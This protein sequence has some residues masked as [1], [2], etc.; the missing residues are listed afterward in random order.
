MGVLMQNGQAVAY[1]SRYLK[2]NDMNYSTHDLELVVIIHDL[3]AQRHYVYGATFNIFTN[4]KS[5]KYLLVYEDINLRERRWL[6]F[7][8][9]YD[10]T[11]SY[12]TRK[13]Q[14]YY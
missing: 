6:Q 1:A 7:I 4:H 8:K 10:F 2:P 13:G 5:I 9:D 12:Q 11:I 3:K 14:C